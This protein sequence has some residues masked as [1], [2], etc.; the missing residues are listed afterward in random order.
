MSVLDSFKSQLLGTYHN[1]FQAYSNPHDF[2]YIT[3]SYWEEDGLIKSH[4]Y[5]TV[6]GPESAYRTNSHNLSEG[7]GGKILMLTYT[8]DD[9]KHPCEMLFSREIIDGWW[10]ANNQRYELIKKGQYV[11][12]YIAFN[13]AEYHS[14]DAGFDSVSNELLWGKIQG[15]EFI[16]HKQSQSA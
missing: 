15:Q 8:E 11:N 12:T 1:R 2:A 3:V 9:P 16:F 6:Y 13:G 14:R 4:S 7:S 10:V 5:H